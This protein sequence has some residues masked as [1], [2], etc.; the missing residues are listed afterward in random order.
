MTLHQREPSDSHLKQPAT[1]AVYS[2]ICRSYH[3]IDGFRMK[4][5]GLL[6]LTSLVGVFLLDRNKVVADFSLSDPSARV[7]VGFAA[8]YAAML[9]LALFLYEV[10][11]IRRTHNL[12]TE[13]KHLELLLGVDHGQFHVCEA[14][15]QRSSLKALNA[16]LIACVI[17]SLVFSGWF[18]LALR[19]GFGRET[20]TCALY[21][22]GAGMMI[23]AFTYFL[24]RKLTPA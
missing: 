13:G 20:R 21:A 24:V 3:E 22:T 10:R 1:L 18:F 4:L 16:K 17:Y 15:H 11:G 6:P 7:L 2:E 5:L 9:T 14:E 23:A 8:I 12:I 19:F